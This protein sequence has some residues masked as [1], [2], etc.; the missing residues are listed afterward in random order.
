MQIKEI[1]KKNNYL[2]DMTESR[3]L[4]AHVLKVNTA[5]L[6]AHDNQLLPA[7]AYQQF[8]MACHRREAGEPMA[9]ILGQK[10]FWSLML[11]V[12]KDTLIP[13]PET[14][15]LI[16][17]TLDL[18]SK[19][20]KT[21]DLHLL[22]L[23]TGSGAVSIAL[24]KALPNSHITAV[25]ICENALKIAKKNQQIHGVFNIDFI[26]SDWFSRLKCKKFDG[27]ISN[28]PYIATQ[29][30][31]LFQG[32]LRFEPLLAL[33]AGKT[34]LEALSC[35]IMQAR[36]YLRPNGFIVLEHGYRQAKKVREFLLQQQ[37]FCVESRKD[38][39]H[40]FRVTFGW[41]S[42]INAVIL[43]EAISNEKKDNENRKN[44]YS[45]K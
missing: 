44:K 21:S 27:I 34:G 35:I 45:S 26:H 5:Y 39:S 43:R 29:D 20:K 32:D 1:L 28:P 19:Q 3:I 38:L 41:L 23:G 22:E 42:D 10:E 6:L 15:L 16:E 30:K 4:L 13:R 36:N 37:F 31:H 25:D 17:T 24:A 14:E 33:V 7:E 9:Y 8:V 18:L 2:Y 40:I 12:S 11:T